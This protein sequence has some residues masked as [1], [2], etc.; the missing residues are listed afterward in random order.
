MPETDPLNLENSPAF[1][2]T[3]EN[4]ETFSVNEDKYSELL[5][6]TYIYKPELFDIPEYPI[7]MS[8]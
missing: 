3:M 4:G 5:K 1:S 8:I 2:F 7:Q 6:I